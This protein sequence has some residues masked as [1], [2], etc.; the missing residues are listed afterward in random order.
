MTGLELP[1]VLSVP[2]GGLSVPA[3]A[4]AWWSLSEADLV[5]DSDVGAVEIYQ[6]LEGTVEA[7][8]TTDIARAAVD[9][10]RAEEDIRKD[11]VVKTHTCWDVPIYASPLPEEVGRSLIELYHRPYHQRLDALAAGKLLGVDC[12]TM[13]EYG[14][15]V[16][17]DP[18]RQRPW[19]CLGDGDGVCPDSWV[20]L[21]AECFSESFG[22]E[23]A[24]N[25]P[26]RGG[27]TVRRWPGGVPWVLLELSRGA[28]ASKE[29]KGRWVL[30]A[31]RRF[32][33]LVGDG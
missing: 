24:V 32:C 4:E 9:M 1:L 27:Y 20:N 19:V 6:P 3:E 23:V 18:G 14:P 5:A 25:E 17:P 21:L 11:G 10:N 8:L 26:F 12:H 33:E 2:H 15:P 28:W 29:E 7:F 22:S 31:L 16:G 13:A 30:R